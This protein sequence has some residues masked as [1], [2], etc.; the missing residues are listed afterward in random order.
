M[1]KKNFIIIMVLILSLM[2]TSLVSAESLSEKNIN[3]LRTNFEAANN[4][5]LEYI[6]EY[7][8]LEGLDNFLNNDYKAFVLANTIDAL[9]S[10]MLPI[11]VIDDLIIDDA[12]ATIYI[13]PDSSFRVHGIRFTQGSTILPASR[14]DTVDETLKKDDFSIQSTARI[15]DHKTFYVDGFAIPSGSPV[16][17]HTFMTVVGGGSSWKLNSYID[18]LSL[19]H[20]RFAY[21]NT[22]GSWSVWPRELLSHQA[23]NRGSSSNT[24]VRT[25]GHY[26]FRYSGLNYPWGYYNEYLQM[27]A[28]IL[29]SGRL[30]IDSFFLSD[31]L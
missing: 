28:Q 24:L 19:S 30:L 14:V 21:A 2:A 13:Y 20:I 3:S 26:Y 1:K 29:S 16:H 6:L 5:A 27:N 4:S 25:E 7:K 11:D 12:H 31:Q 23:R 22:A 18:V 15:V 10:N 17:V 9:K 8:T